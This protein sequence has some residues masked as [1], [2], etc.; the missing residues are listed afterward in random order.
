MPAAVSFPLEAFTIKYE[1]AW[2]IAFQQQ[3]SDLRNSVTTVAASGERVHG[4]IL[5]AVEMVDITTRAGDTIVSDMGEDSWNFFPNPAA[6]ALRF[7][8]W[9]EAYLG[10]ITQP[11]SE[12]AASQAYACNRFIDE[13]IVDAALGDAY[14]GKNGTDVVALPA[15]QVVAVDYAGDGVTPANTGLS[16]MKISQAQYLLSTAEVPTTERYL[17]TNAAGLKAL[18]QDIITNHSAEVSSIRD[19]GRS[20]LQNGLMDFT[21]IQ[22]ERVPVDDSDIASNLAY[23]KSAIK[24]G[25]WTDR[26]TLM[27][28]LPTKNQALQIYTSVNVGATRAKDL[29]VVEILCDQSPA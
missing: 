17:V 16:W 24:F 6:N 25:M 21:F 15:S 9:D 26:R 12:V 28:R 10:V 8:Q 13:I 18:I 29:G 11:N 19:L 4:N 14:R 7:D 27:D 1:L 22:T 5:D 2:D 23:H 3:N 20:L